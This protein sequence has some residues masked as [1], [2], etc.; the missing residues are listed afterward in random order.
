MQDCV[1][2]RGRRPTPISERCLP[3]LASLYGFRN[4]CAR[5]Y[6]MSMTPRYWLPLG[7]LSSVASLLYEGGTTQEK[8]EYT[9]DLCMYFRRFRLLGDS[10]SLVHRQAL[11]KQSR[12]ST[13][14]RSEVAEP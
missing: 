1:D 8:Q 5:C 6:E 14:R 9:E 7:R 2:V 4:S 10:L 11:A 3:V 13:Q 12:E